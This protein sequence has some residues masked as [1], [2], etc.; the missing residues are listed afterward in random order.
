MSQ[1]TLSSSPQQEEET[2]VHFLRVKG[3]TFKE[4]VYENHFFNIFNRQ[5]FEQ[6]FVQRDLKALAA[7]ATTD[8]LQNCGIRSLVWKVFLSLLPG[9]CLPIKKDAPAAE[10]STILDMY[11]K[12]YQQLKEKHIFD[13]RKKTEEMGGDLESF[14]PLSTQES[15]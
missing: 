12:E 9:S 4:Q 1:Q 11:R 14:N 6:L 8:G 13:P 10:M 2:Q 5:E 3:S 7:K 15:V